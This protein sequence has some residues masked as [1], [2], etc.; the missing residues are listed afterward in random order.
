MNR[1][2]LNRILRLLIIVAAAA[3]AGCSLFSSD[4]P[5][6]AKLTPIQDAVPVKKLWNA[7]VGNMGAARAGW[8]Y[9]PF[10]VDPE[11]I[12][13]PAGPGGSVF[14]AT[15]D[16][17]IARYDV[18]TGAPA[19][20]IKLG[21]TISGGV[22]V[23]ADGSMVVVGTGK[24]DVLAYDGGGKPI[25]KAQVTSEILSPPAIGEGIVVVRSS[26]NRIFGLN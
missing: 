16:G 21:Q 10:A 19:W 8:D 23:S 6:M 17:S 5:K 4:K 12:F 1:A 25:W 24:G 9:S 7:S 20:R 11:N 15:Q 26:D 3:S 22:G 14:A 18:T 13:L 2:L